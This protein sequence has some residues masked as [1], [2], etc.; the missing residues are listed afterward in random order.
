MAG[1]N[2]IGWSDIMAWRA[3]MGINPLPW[4]IRT[5]KDLDNAFLR[6]MGEKK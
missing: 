5:L 3:C 1:P 4:E 2:P 6:V